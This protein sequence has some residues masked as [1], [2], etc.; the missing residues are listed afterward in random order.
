MWFNSFVFN[1]VCFQCFQF[2]FPDVFR[3]QRKGTYVAND[4]I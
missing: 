4:L 3:G 2:K 1:A